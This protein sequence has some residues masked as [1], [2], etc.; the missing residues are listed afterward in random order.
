MNRQTGNIDIY[1]IGKSADKTAAAIALVIT[2]LVHLGLYFAA[3]SA[4][5]NFSAAHKSEP[6]DELKLEILPPKIIKKIPDF[7][8]A[9]PFAN[10]EKPASPDAPESFTDQRAAD[11]LPDPSSKSKM[12]YVEGEIKDGRKIVEGTSSPEDALNPQAPLETL[13]RPLEQ[14]AQ[15]S[16]VETPAQNQTAATAQ[17]PQKSQPQADAQPEAAQTPKSQPEAETS[18]RY[19]I[20]AKS[21]PFPTADTAE[22][23]VPNTNPDGADGKTKTAQTNAEKISE[24]PA[25]K[26]AQAKE[27]SAQNQSPAQTEKQPA[28]NADTPTPPIDESLPAPKPRPY[29]SMKIPAGPLADNR[30]RAS[31]QG[32][33]AVDSRFSEFGAY[34]QRM[35]EAISRQWNLLGS[36]YDLNTAVNTI[37]VVEYSLN[38][39]GELTAISTPFSNSTNTGRGLCEQSILTTAPYG[40]WTRDMIAALGE[41]DQ[42]VRITFHYR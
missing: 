30:T 7:V 5:L 16:E 24:A 31:S 29:L 3:P 33:V 27:N 39:N 32:T 1:S 36:A 34:Q 17:Q 4:F 21:S 11:I 25:Q 37:V 8:E 42:Q 22:E 10:T 13:E 38:K 12:P 18:E 14:P 19:D 2:L 41:Q 26:Q 28:Q 15:V 40:E 20:G 23:K 6:D 9:N 35:I